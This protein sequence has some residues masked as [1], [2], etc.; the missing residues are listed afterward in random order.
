MR[1]RKPAER[2][3]TSRATRCKNNIGWAWH[4][5]TRKLSGAGAAKL[6]KDRRGSACTC[7]DHREFAVPA[8]HHQTKDVK[9]RC[10]GVICRPQCVSG[11][12]RGARVEGARGWGRHGRIRELW[13][14]ETQSVFDDLME[15]RLLFSY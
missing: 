11:G 3:I 13:N 1:Q 2:A 14:L 12:G 8:A 5:H 9:V 6:K 15:A 7:L 10:G 4:A